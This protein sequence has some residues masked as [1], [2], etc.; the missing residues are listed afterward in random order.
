[1]RGK[2]HSVSEY[3]FGAGGM[4]YTVRKDSPDERCEWSIML[5]QKGNG[6]YRVYIPSR[7]MV[8][9]VR[10]FVESKS[11]PLHWGWKRR[12][13]FISDGKVNSL[14]DNIESNRRAKIDRE[15]NDV[16][17]ENDKLLEN[18]KRVE[19]EDKEIGL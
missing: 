10:K 18:D 9:S 7:R 12:E 4:A 8:Y 6:D 5:E 11:Y 2:K 1:M 19:E 3:G 14:I 13:Q 15:V 16:K 17:L